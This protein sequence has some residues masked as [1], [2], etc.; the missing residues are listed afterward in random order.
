MPLPFRRPLAFLL[1]L[2][3]VAAACGRSDEPGDP[4]NRNSPPAAFDLSMA[5]LEP[6]SLDPPLIVTDSATVIAKQVCDTLI[7]F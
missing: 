1:S 7:S 4:G 5:I 6:G 2:A 3:L